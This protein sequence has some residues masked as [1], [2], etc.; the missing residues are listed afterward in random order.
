MKKA[1]STGVLSLVLGAALCAPASALTVEGVDV[2]ET[3]SAMVVMVM[4]TTLAT[5][6][7]LKY[8][9]AGKDD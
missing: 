5:P 6:P 1:L 2:P 8:L 3:Y 9:M 7:L 4:V